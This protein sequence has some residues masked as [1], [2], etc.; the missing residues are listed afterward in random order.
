M[1]NCFYHHDNKVYSCCYNRL[2]KPVDQSCIF[3][4]HDICYQFIECCEMEVL[5]ID[6]WE[7]LFCDETC[8]GNFDYG[9]VSAIK[10]NGN[11]KKESDKDSKGNSME[12]MP[13]IKSK[14]L[15]P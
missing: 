9:K 2:C 12:Q 13:K 8:R 4:L 15:F 14:N 1:S 7:L 5:I 11:D 3:L 10:V 6:P